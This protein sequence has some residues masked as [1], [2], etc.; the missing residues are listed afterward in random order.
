MRAIGFQ[1]FRKFTDFP[2]MEFAPITIFVGG[3]N[4][5]KST[6]VKG[7][8]SLND[9]LNS[10]PIGE[11]EIPY[12]A[13]ERQDIPLEPILKQKKKMLKEQKFYFN[14]NPY[15]HIGTFER[16]QNNTCGTND[17]VFNCVMGNFCMSIEVI[18]GKDKELPYGFISKVRIIDLIFNITITFDLF[19]DQALVE[20]RPYASNMK[21]IEASSRKRYF[22]VLKSPCSFTY[23]ISDYWTTEAPTLPTSLLASFNT[24][25]SYTLTIPELSEEE[26]KEPP[27]TRRNFC[28]FKIVEGITEEALNAFRAI[29]SRP[30]PNSYRPTKEA[31]RY[32]RFEIPSMRAAYLRGRQ[33]EYIYSHAVSQN[34]WYVA[35][36]TD[37]L[38]KTVHEFATEQ[39]KSH[40]RNLVELWMDENHFNIG[41]TFQIV[42]VGGEA[43][44]VKIT[45]F[46]G[47]VT[48]L[49]DKGMGTI[50]L[51]VL[52]FRLAIAL[53]SK[54]RMRT[55][56]GFIYEDNTPH[57][58]IVEEP[59]QNIHPKL[60]SLLADLFYDMFTDYGFHFI[61]ETHSE[62][63]VRKT[64]VKVKELAQKT[65]TLNENPFKV[66]F[67]NSVKSDSESC[68][69]L[70]PFKDMMYR[71]DG[72]FDE[73]FGKGFFD[74]ATRLAFQILS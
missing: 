38:S 66:Y 22:D 56:G 41:K 29:A 6:V 44:Q 71:V 68:T 47:T 24:A 2:L 67:F 72:K 23:C 61:V 62:Y 64:Q 19:A 30:M 21:E 58:I 3:N 65:Q 28:S 7:L 45:D 43:F 35:G 37:Y 32:L 59:E 31:Y 69:A 20:M 26:K 40:K 15:T 46:D 51:M 8:L 27:F 5:G 36:A 11:I 57:V 17:I 10:T 33:M 70:T 63:L 73:E 34:V 4:A 48:D 52:L 18:K 54:K 50:Q 25:I 74:E 1:N 55:W 14:S 49:A 42:S 12:S 13:R 60:Q 16:A 53:P 9:F 39:N